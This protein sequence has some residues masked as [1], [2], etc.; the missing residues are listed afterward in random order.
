MFKVLN[1]ETKASGLGHTRVRDSSLARPSKEETPTL[2]CQRRIVARGKIYL[3]V[4]WKGPITMNRQLA[5]SLN[6]DRVLL[7][8][9]SDT[10]EFKG[11]IAI[12]L[13]NVFAK[14]DLHFY[15]HYHAT[16]PGYVC[17]RQGSNRVRQTDE[18]RKICQTNAF[19][20]S[21]MPQRMRR[22]RGSP[23]WIVGPSI[24]LKRKLKSKQTSCETW[25]WIDVWHQH[26]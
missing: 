18:L 8:R 1:V 17:P 20:S 14:S 4:V 16:L 7:S 12:N 9:H 23:R 10:N 22:T 26:W 24:D 19:S 3:K 21:S 25:N 11:S 2:I 5:D 6:G 15:R 13:W